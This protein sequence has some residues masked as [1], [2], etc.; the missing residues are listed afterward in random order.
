MN[1]SPYHN[2]PPQ[3]PQDRSLIERVQGVIE[4]FKDG[5][6]VIMVDDKLR[7]NEGDLVVAAEDASAQTIN[8]MAKEA[9]GLICL[10]MEAALIDRLKLP[11]MSDHSKSSESR[12]TAFTV[13]IEA[14]H[15]VS[16]G[17]SAQ[18]RAT[19]IQRAIHDHT[20]PDDIVVP[21]HIFPLKARAGGVLTR[22]GHTEGSV[23]LAKLAQKKPASVICEIMNDD[24]TMARMND[25]KRFSKKHNIPIISIQELI[26]YRLLYDSL[27]KECKRETLNTRYGTFEACWF[28]SE[29]DL[30][31]HVAL[32]KGQPHPD[33]PTEVRVYRQRF[34]DDIFGPLQGVTE[35]RVEHGLKMLASCE[36][37]V[38]LYLSAPIF[39]HNPT[40]ARNPAEHEDTSPQPIKN[41]P[42]PRLYGIGAQIL[43]QLGVG[44][45]ILNTMS[46]RSFTAIAGFGL[47]VVGH[48]VIGNK[49]TPT[50]M[51]SPS[52]SNL[53]HHTTATTKAIKTKHTN[54]DK[55]SPK[56]SQHR[57][58]I[59][60]AKWH[61]EIVSDL[62]KGAR[63]QFTQSGIKEKQI[64]HW[65]VP[66]CYEL[67]TAAQQACKQ[68]YWN[69]LLCF[70][71]LI[72]GHTIHHQLVAE[73]VNKAFVDIQ[74][75]YHIPIIHG[76]LVC[77]TK[78]L[79]I[80]RSATT[81]KKHRGKEA[82]HTAVEL[83]SSSWYNKP[84]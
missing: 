49:T 69:I 15:G 43:R 31:C 33:H 52:L 23:D 12:K 32:L 54:T 76:L 67:I 45:L 55:A 59:I 70:G 27:V 63:S 35:R 30:S 28:E 73:A 34:L 13:S 6:M 72:K 80:E 14:K 16:T 83:L 65:Q 79:A 44:K 82:A 10:P 78:Q 53:A 3:S 37:G 36:V 7:E 57:Y 58:L 48:R 77:D 11:M 39:S 74:L 22:A 8:F 17:I 66:G 24:G 2:N 20:C 40:Q 50:P 29:V 46:P 38:Y 41:M 26:T 19:T 71:C 25:L 62:I 18:D 42:D 84:T 21:G 5:K 1:T 75:T 60:S 68:G 56:I 47:D 81:S 9:R 51:A 61:D 64:E 4:H